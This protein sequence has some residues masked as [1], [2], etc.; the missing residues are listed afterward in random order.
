VGLG[1]YAVEMVRTDDF[2][3]LTFSD[4]AIPLR[5]GDTAYL[6]Y[7]SWNSLRD[8]MPLGI[9]HGS[10]GTVDQVLQLAGD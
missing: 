2:D 8:T 4:D 1:T 3:E 10:T 5:S 7:G 9:D 6:N